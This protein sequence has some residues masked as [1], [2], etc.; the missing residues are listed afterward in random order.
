MRRIVKDTIK[1]TAKS[2]DP[3]KR[4]HCFEIFGYDFMLDEEFKPWL[5]EVNTN[6]CLALSGKLLAK[7]IPEMIFHSFEIVLDQLFPIRG[8]SFENN[9]YELIFAESVDR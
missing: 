5:I 3:N 1:A 7:L 4:T 2:L 8:S 9:L 6:P